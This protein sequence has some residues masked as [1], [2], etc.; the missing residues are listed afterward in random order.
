MDLL[1]V[2]EVHA[3]LKPFLPLHS[4]QIPSPCTDFS[5]AGKGAEGENAFVTVTATMIALKLGVPLILYENLPRMLQ[6]KAWSMAAALLA[7]AGYVWSSVVVNAIDC[8][9]PQ[10][11]Q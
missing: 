9:V 1:Q 2:E 10:N 11:R 8:G 7:A 5:T 3:A 6:S 4:V